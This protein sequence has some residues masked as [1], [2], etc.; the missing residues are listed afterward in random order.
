MGL[1]SRTQP[2]WSTDGRMTPGSYT[3]KS[4]NAQNVKGDKDRLFPK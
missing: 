4:L 1:Q 2:T 3:L